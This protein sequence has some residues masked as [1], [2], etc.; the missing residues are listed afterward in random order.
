MFNLNLQKLCEFVWPWPC[1][2]N[3]AVSTDDIRQKL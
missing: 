2:F 3:D 1:T